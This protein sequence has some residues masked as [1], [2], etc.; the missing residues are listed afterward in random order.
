M[1]EADLHGKIKEIE[2]HEDL[3]TSTVFGMAKYISNPFIPYLLSFAKT[4][5]DM[6]FKDAINF[7]LRT[8]TPKIFFWKKLPSLREPDIIIEFQDADKTYLLGVEVK[9][10]S[11]KSG[12]GEDDQ[13][14]RY[15]QDLMSKSKNENSIFLGIVYLT[16]YPAYEDLK[17][18]LRQIEDLQLDIDA[19]NMLFTLR[20]HDVT[21]A[22]ME[23]L[24]RDIPP[25]EKLILY[26]LIRYLKHK[27]L[28]EFN[29]FSFINKTLD[30]LHEYHYVSKKKVFNG[31]SFHSSSFVVPN[32]EKIL[33]T[34]A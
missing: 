13:L 17:D 6:S 24:K 11:P 9:F 1:I 10:Y 21:R 16:K 29:G 30:A 18:S 15:F 4:I 33:Y 8:S 19:K 31:F 14:K 12:E 23:Y 32:E 2:N 7:D 20:W 5:K 26:D 25:I 34:H 22:I 27:N 3:L 28:V